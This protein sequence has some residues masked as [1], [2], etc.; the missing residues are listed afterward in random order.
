MIIES[1]CFFST[2][3][4]NQN[5]QIYQVDKNISTAVHVNSTM[6]N[7]I[8]S[9]L[10]FAICLGF[11]CSDGSQQKVTNAI[12]NTS[13]SI[14]N[15][16]SEL[17]DTLKNVRDEIKSKIPK[18]EINVSKSVSIGLQWISFESEKGTAEITKKADNWFVIKG[19]QTNS[20][21]EYLKIN[22]RMKRLDANRVSFEGTIITYIKDNNGG[23]PCEKTG[24]QV[25]LKKGD[26]VYYR[27]QNMENCAGGRLLDY[28]DIYNLDEVL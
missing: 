25:F 4:T 15:K 21:N 7:L 16:L 5:R 23:V 20:Q 13:D 9:C 10:I 22:G 19:E 11:G 24:A 6:K 28:V 3:A 26:R 17:N 14:S 8:K 12:D 2:I 18:V 27:L 1:E